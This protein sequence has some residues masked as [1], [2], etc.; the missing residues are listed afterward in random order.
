MLFVDVL[1]IKILV[2]VQDLLL[3]HCFNSAGLSHNCFNWPNDVCKNTTRNQ[4]RD[5]SKDLLEIR[6]WVYVSI[7]N[8][9][10]RGKGPV[11]RC[12][13]LLINWWIL[14]IELSQPAISILRQLARPNSKEYTSQPMSHKN[15][16]ADNLHQIYRRYERPIS[17]HF[18]DFVQNLFE[19]ENSQKTK[20]PQKSC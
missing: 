17:N 20:K 16:E 9:C 8:C 14:Q 15:N 6:N 12:N 3:E 7:S 1:A 11:Q 13:I 10:H 18:F 5:H 4:H 19:F 2:H